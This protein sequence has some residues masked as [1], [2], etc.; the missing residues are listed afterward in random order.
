MIC[1]DVAGDRRRDFGAEAESEFL[2]VNTEG[3]SMIYR[4]GECEVD[5]TVGELRVGGEPVHVEPQVFSLLLF[6]L[7]NPGRLVTREEL[8]DSVWGHRFVAP[9]T[10]S[11]RLRA[12]RQAIGDDGKDQRYIRTLRGR[13]VRFVAPVEV[14]EPTGWGEPR[15]VPESEMGAPHLA[16]APPGVD[17]ERA[18]EPPLIARE[19]E[20]QG[21]QGQLTE[22]R[23]GVRRVVLL[24]GE[25][26][27]GKSALA[28]A[29]LASLP[30]DVRIG[31][32]QC[33]ELQGQGEP[34][35][36]VLDALGRLIRGEQGDQVVRLLATHAPTWLAQMPALL[37]RERLEEAQRR[38]LGAT[39]ERMLREIV[40]A[41]EVL[42]RDTPLVILLEDL[43]WS[44][45]STLEFLV[46]FAQRPDPARVLL[47][48]TLRSSDPG[49]HVRAALERLQR[50]GRCI[51]Q[52]LDGWT[53][54]DIE[55]YCATSHPGVEVPP[56]VIALAH[57]SSGGNPFF[58]RTLLDDW[59]ERDVIGDLALSSSGLADELPVAIPETL[60]LLLE[61]QVE[62]LPED[63]QR[64][65]EAASVLG[66]DF[67]AHAAGELTGIGEERADAC[68]DTLARQGQILRFAGTVDLPTGGWSARYEFR[69]H[70]IRDVL[71]D[72]LTLAARARLHLR[73]AEYLE[74]A[75]GEG[76][77]EEV[78]LL[79]H[80]F[81]LGRDE[82]RAASYL[83]LC[84]E[85]ALGR[86]AYE[87]A[88][89]QLQKGLEMLRRRRD[90]PN[91]ASMELS[92]QRMLGSALLVTRG[93]GDPDAERAYQRARE[94][95]EQIQDREELARV[96]YSMA[97]LHELRG[98]FQKSEALL[99]ERLSLA[100][101]EG[102]EE[103]DL[104]AYELLSCSLFHQG[105]FWKAL[106]N[107]R[108]ALAA[109]DPSRNDPFTASLGDNAAVASHYWWGL[110]LWFI[111]CPEQA[112]GPVQ[113]AVRLA[114]KAQLV[115][116]RAAARTQAARLHHF[117]GEPDL[118]LTNATIALLTA[119]RQGY[120]Y[121]EA[122]A[123]TLRGWARV[124]KGEIPEGI[125]E[126][127]RGLSMQHAAGAD[128]ERPYGLG[129][130]A[131]AFLFAGRPE[132]GIAA[133]T[134][135]LETIARRSRTFFWEAE[136]QRLEGELRHRAG[137][138]QL[139]LQ[140]LRS[141]SELANRQGAVSLRLR[142]ALSLARLTT[143]PA[144][145]AEARETLARIFH[146]FEEGFDT[147]DLRG[148]R[149]MLAAPPPPQ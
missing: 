46:W 22:V 86:G 50:T 63:V 76:E 103:S 30:A 65:L 90:I 39:R 105:R 106:E 128:M 2:R 52:Q 32:G 141:A 18:G 9:A 17:P 121:H 67:S 129:L 27:I 35:L 124:R 146:S 42:G 135:A 29:F 144:E 34:Y 109:F 122:V 47:L 136:L 119:Q 43:H 145:R 40:E 113:T 12:L 4:F 100:A 37:D 78:S 133:T 77:A 93:W 31:R 127:R 111:G 26:G 55:A 72:R 14:I 66:V 85:Q 89:G 10:L 19:P 36:P 117:R 38:S 62:R 45:P 95:S 131:E 107:A 70:L 33:V 60:R 5:P 13:G 92:I 79:A 16:A 56:E 44:D 123:L 25:P 73:A 41:L 126:I 96:L 142:A 61:A 143:D 97:Y 69:H 98:D 1:R 137:E 120:P 118:V 83:I 125:E 148:A 134:E 59:I 102:H 91:A 94:I 68:C 140:R 82:A 101:S 51:E 114:E 58:A 57:R 49:S 99:R 80:H 81:I 71:Y 28:E 147:A 6:L 138:T 115:Y 64:L 15:R 139:A 112:L 88:V 54:D 3:G 48:G 23:N 84:A 75:T 149:Q 21:L 87:E 132:E 11:S 53:P 7:S 74:S 20:I 108:A 104:E 110:T 116:M 24:R 130:L 8:L